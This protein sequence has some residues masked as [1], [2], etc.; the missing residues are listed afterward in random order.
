MAVE[1][2]PGTIDRG[3]TRERL[4]VTWIMEEALS[5]YK[6]HFVSLFV[7]FLVA[8]L[9]VWMVQFYS[10]AQ[11]ANIL[12]EHALNLTEIMEHPE[13]SASLGV[14]LLADL[15]VLFLL[16]MVAVY[17]I[18]LLFDGAAIKYVY[19]N[20]QGGAPEWPQCFSECIQ[21]FPRLVAATIAAGVIVAL[22]LIAFVI[23][24]LVFLTM[25]VLV[26]Q[27]VILEGKGP[28]AALSR[29]NQLSSGNKIAI[30]CFFLFWAMVLVLFYMLL[31]L[32][33]PAQLA[34]VGEFV[35]SALFSPVV[36]V[37]T[38]LIYHRVRESAI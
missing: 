27:T 14:S 19:D 37:S 31:L 17:L 6:K 16:S 7:V 33:V 30:F 38:T 13:Q 24:G 2:L 3:V 1:P 25:F 10:A 8:N 36:P 18:S 35:A 28:L 22:G 9:I 32:A 29:S 26:P 4:R 15:L 5:F 21:R 11:V 12:E 23:P 20:L 34:Q